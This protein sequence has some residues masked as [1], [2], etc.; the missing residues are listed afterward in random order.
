M[1]LPVSAWMSGQYGLS[2][3]YI[4]SPAVI[5]GDGA[6]TVIMAALSS[7]EQMQM[8]RSAEILRAVTADAL[9]N[10]MK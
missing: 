9:A 3:M 1:V 4:G 2:D 8:Q 5:N 6:K 10:F 7:A